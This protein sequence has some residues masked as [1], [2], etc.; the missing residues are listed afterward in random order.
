MARGILLILLLSLLS[1]SGDKCYTVSLEGGGL[2]G[3]YEAGVM[4]ALTE[5]LPPS[6]VQYNFMSGISI[7][8]YN[9]C[10]CSSFAFG[11]ERNMAIHLQNV[12][13]SITKKSQMFKYR[14]V[15]WALFWAPS[16]INNSPAFNLILNNIGDQV[17]RN[18]TVGTTDINT[19]EL[20]NYNESLPTEDLATACFASGAFPGAFPPVPFKG[21]YYID[22]YAT[23]NIN[24]FILINKCKEMGYKD[25]DIVVDLL[26][27][28]YFEVLAKD[29][30]NKT[31]QTMGKI[32]KMRQIFNWDWFKLQLKDDFPD[33]E[34][35]YAI[36]P[37]V[38]LSSA[39]IESRYKI[40]L[41]YNDTL[42]VLKMSKAERMEN[43][44]K[45]FSFN[46]HF[47]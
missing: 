14:P 7:G 13:L 9:T 19:G 11:D 20:I 10:W 21:S 41:G 27:D 45:R 35:R 29:R 33:I 22:G 44:K 43:F 12:W 18:V 40:D 32:D 3:P 6:E 42:K 2:K 39:K 17:R 31:Q 1:A 23:I 25:E 34:V 4:M 30:V 47:S 36:S 26:Y 8:S 46:P 37:S 24:A 28:E 16:L 15:F 38:P 5:F